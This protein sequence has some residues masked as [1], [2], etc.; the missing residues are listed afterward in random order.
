MK[1]LAQTVLKFAFELVVAGLT[2]WIVSPSNRSLLLPILGGIVLVATAVSVAPLERDVGSRVAWRLTAWAIF[3]IVAGVWSRR[4]WVPR[5]E[6]PTLGEIIL[7]FVLP[8]LAV[9]SAAAVVGALVGRRFRE[10]KAS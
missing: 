9:V 7:S 4:T 8:S 3:L 6:M 1:Q 2:I 5:A 10:Q